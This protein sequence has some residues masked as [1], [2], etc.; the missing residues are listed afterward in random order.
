MYNLLLV[1][2]GRALLRLTAIVA[3]TCIVLLSVAC[4]TSTAQNQSAPPDLVAPQQ[5]GGGYSGGNASA[6][7]QAGAAFARWVLDQDPQR[8]FITDAIVRNESSL[9]VKVQPN[10]TKADLQRLLV[11][12]TQGMARTFPGKP[13]TVIAFYQSGDKLA[14]ANFDPGTNQVSVQFAQ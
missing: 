3:L 7:T 14:Q 5:Y 10:V 12:L 1:A 9:G 11:A 8:Q 13:L 6:D 4:G 2:R